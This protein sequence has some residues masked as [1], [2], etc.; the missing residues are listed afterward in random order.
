MLRARGSTGFGGIRAATR[1]GQACLGSR[2]TRRRDCG[3]QVPGGLPHRHEAGQDDVRRTAS[4]LLTAALVP[5]DER[6]IVQVINARLVTYLRNVC[7]RYLLRRTVTPGERLELLPDVLS[8]LPETSIR[9]IFG[10]SVPTA[11][12]SQLRGRRTPSPTISGCTPTSSMS[13]LTL[14]LCWLCPLRRWHSP[15]RCCLLS[16]RVPVARFSLQLAARPAPQPVCTASPALPHEA[17]M[18]RAAERSSA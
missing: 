13:P 15:L 11:G 7:K 2:S 16:G 1:W 8:L 4:R 17:W 10:A 9:A 12:H 14:R 3:V 18:T 6:W 5:A